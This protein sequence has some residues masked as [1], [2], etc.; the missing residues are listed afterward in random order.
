MTTGCYDALPSVISDLGGAPKPSDEDR[1]ASLRF[2]DFLI[3]SQL[4][5]VT[6]CASHNAHC[7]HTPCST[8]LLQS[9]R[10]PFRASRLQDPLLSTAAT[11]YSNQKLVSLAQCIPTKMPSWHTIL[12][13]LSIYMFRGQAACLSGSMPARNDDE[14]RNHA[15]WQWCLPCLLLP[16]SSC[17]GPFVKTIPAHLLTIVARAKAMQ[18]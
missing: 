18:T 7:M 9:L 12:P 10:L 13:V 17:L 2:M 14:E 8:R 3:R 1:K 15:D 5:R 6:P 11:I 16:C 4:L